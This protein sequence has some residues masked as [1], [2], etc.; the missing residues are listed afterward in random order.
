MSDI[1]QRIGQVRLIPVIAIEDAANASPLGQALL[2]GGLPVAEIT[3]RTSAAEQSIRALSGL[4]ELLIGAG[5][6]LNVETAKRALGA[7]AKFIVAPG[8]NPKVV[9][10]CVNNKV[11]IFPGAVTPTEIE[12]A[13]DLG[14]DTVKFFPADSF[15]G[16][17][18]IK[19]L[20]APY[21]MMKFIPTGG[22][23]LD[24]LVEYL[25]FPKILAIGGSW[26]ATKELIAAKNFSKITELA[27][28]A[29]DVAKGI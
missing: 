8:L 21:S 16:L 20:S 10:Y 2:A 3:F 29:V 11:P 27:Q 14:I 26:M 13:M 12:A 19:S 23:N 24:N 1:M 25:K 22:I 18:G 4:P 6:V 28:Q 5:T 9:N 15:G 7:G 17:K